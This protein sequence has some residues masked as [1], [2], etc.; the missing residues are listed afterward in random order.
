MVPLLRLLH[1][2]GGA[3]HREGALSALGV[4]AGAADELVAVDSGQPLIHERQQCLHGSLL[5]LP[6]SHVALG[7]GEVR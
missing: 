5:L 3:F 4:G 6:W 1:V 7:Y 2:C